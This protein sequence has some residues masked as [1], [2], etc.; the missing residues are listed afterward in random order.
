MKG[1]HQMSLKKLLGL[2]NFS[3]SE[4]E[5]ISKIQHAYRL[6]KSELEFSNKEN[7]VR[8]RLTSGAPPGLMEST[9]QWGG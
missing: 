2:E 7:I 1:G 4:A 5:I 9:M 3:L 8:V 6:N